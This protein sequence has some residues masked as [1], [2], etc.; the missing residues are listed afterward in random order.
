MNTKPAAKANSAHHS[1]YDW[2][3]LLILVLLWGTAF[4]LLKTAVSEI[5]P[6]TVVMGRLWIGAVML[7][8]W[9][10]FRGYAM[11]RLISSKEKPMDRLWLWFMVL[12]ITGGTVPFA[13]ISWGQKSLDSA[14]VGILMAIMPLA[15]VAMAHFFV[16]GE[17]MNV[18][19]LIGFTI[20]FIGVVV[21]MGP[22]AL[23]GL[24]GHTFIAQIAVI[25]GAL[26]YAVQTI[27]ARNMPPVRPSVAAA[28][29]LICAALV[30]TP[31]GLYAAMDMPI[32]GLG[33]QVSVLGLGLGATGLGGILLMAVIRDAGPSFLSLSNYLMPLVAVFVGISIG[34][35]L[36]LNVWIALFIILTGLVLAGFRSKSS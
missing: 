21:L 35:H 30:I 17:K 2:S 15:T 34:E 1:F 27:I 31:F 10:K 13:L 8:I 19:K 14:L 5:P 16:A 24:G 4:A 29:L 28:G 22:A 7:L 23:R 20:G 11:P 26:F 32:P 33:A 9:V 6:A 25:L 18:R 12:G 3:R 36:G